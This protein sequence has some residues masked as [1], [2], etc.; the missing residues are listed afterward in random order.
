MSL[1]RWSHSPWYIY[2]AD[3]ETLQVS[4]FGYFT[5]D[6][7]LDKSKVFNALKTDRATILESIELFIWIYPWALGQ[8]GYIPWKTYLK[9]LEF[10]RF[11]SYIRRYTV[12]Y[13]SEFFDYI[14]SDIEKLVEFIK[15]KVF[16][17]TKPRKLT[18]KEIKEIL[19]EYRNKRR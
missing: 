1:C 5:A 17:S 2:E 6:E 3:V 19:N 9:I 12:D 7:I 4:M 8:K 11:V 15:H 13:N 14:Q 16:P 18:K 10:T